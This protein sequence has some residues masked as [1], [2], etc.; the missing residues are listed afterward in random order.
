MIIRK[1][2]FYN[3]A[4]MDEILVETAMA[5]NMETKGKYPLAWRVGALEAVSSEM[6]TIRPA[7]GNLSGLFLRR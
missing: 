1:N 3:Y 6:T 2:V 5:T 4:E 7:L